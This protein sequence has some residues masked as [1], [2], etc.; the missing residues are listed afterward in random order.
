MTLIDRRTFAGLVAGGAAVA[1]VEVGRRGREVVVKLEET[2]E[3]R[4]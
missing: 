4:E 2:S 1:S 3:S